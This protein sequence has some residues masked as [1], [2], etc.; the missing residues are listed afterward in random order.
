MK[1]HEKVYSTFKVLHKENEALKHKAFCAVMGN[2][3]IK[4][5]RTKRSFISELYMNICI[6]QLRTNATIMISELNT[7]ANEVKF[8][9][10]HSQPSSTNADRTSLETFRKLMAFWNIIRTR[11]ATELKAYFTFARSRIGHLRRRHP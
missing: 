7:E 6:K 5:S 2:S 11:R 4:I 8:P 1:C 9:T 10:C 3:R